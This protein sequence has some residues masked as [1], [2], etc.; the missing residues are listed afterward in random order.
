MQAT[1]QRRRRGW[2]PP[3]ATRA[4]RREAAASE[5]VKA[6][7]STSRNPG[8]RGR[9]LVRAGQVA[10]AR[11]PSHRN[12]GETAGPAREGTEIEPP[13]VDISLHN[14]SYRT[15][16]GAENRPRMNERS[17]PGFVLIAST[18][19]LLLSSARSRSSRRDGSSAKPAD[20]LR[21]AERPRA[22]GSPANGSRARRQSRRPGSRWSESPLQARTPQPRH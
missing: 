21:R 20:R 8:L 9:M 22:D 14:V 7:T 2:E 11:R 12:S 16:C 13:F 15:F 6:N 19:S 17:A 3:V 4:S 1:L 5:S 10:P 18:G